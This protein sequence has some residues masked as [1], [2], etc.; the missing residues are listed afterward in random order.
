VSSEKS[1]VEEK[2]KKAK[3]RAKGIDLEFLGGGRKISTPPRFKPLLTWSI[4]SYGRALERCYNFDCYLL[5]STTA[6][7]TIPTVRIATQVKIIRIPVLITFCRLEG[8]FTYV[9]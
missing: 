9:T 5:P 8:S 7:A 4:D 1:V 2:D 3:K 6:T